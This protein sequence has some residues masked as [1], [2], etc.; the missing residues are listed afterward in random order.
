M[1]TQSS[2]DM[3][4]KH[5]AVAGEMLWMLLKQGPVPQHQN[6]SPPS[7]R[8]TLHE[9]SFSGTSGPAAQVRAK[10]TPLHLLSGRLHQCLRITRTPYEP[11]AR[12]LPSQIAQVQS[13]TKVLEERRLCTLSHS[14]LSP[15]N[16]RIHY[17]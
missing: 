17:C 12:L 8:S 9:S 2:S 1:D 6:L 15:M 14:H 4:Q 11:N 13:V 10:Q 7:L 16:E 5:A 3:K